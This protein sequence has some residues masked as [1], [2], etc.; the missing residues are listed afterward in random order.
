M[1]NYL[2]QIRFFSVSSN[3]LLFSSVFLHSYCDGLVS[4]L[5]FV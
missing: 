2:H 5:D 1:Q 4:K 3:N